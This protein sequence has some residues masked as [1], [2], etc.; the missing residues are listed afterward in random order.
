MSLNAPRL[1]IV[2]YLDEDVDVDLVP[3]LHQQDYEAYTVRDVG[4]RGLS[5]EE[6]LR[7]ATERGWTIVTH[8]VN[9]F[10]RL[11]SKWMQQGK[12]HAGIIVSKRL[13]IGRMLRTLLNLLNQVSAEEAKNQ[14]FYLSNF[15]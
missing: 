5:D 13:E 14:L 11:H 12:A 8:N 6:Q 1:Y 2:S 15:E 9:D 10:K 7:F 4:R 3:A